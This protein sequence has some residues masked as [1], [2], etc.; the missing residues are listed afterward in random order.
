MIFITTHRPYFEEELIH[1]GKLQANLLLVDCAVFQFSS[2]I[3]IL[4]LLN[5]LSTSHVIT[6]FVLP[7]S[8]LL[9]GR[10][11]SDSAAFL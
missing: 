10:L 8:F 3:C 11:V 1:S 2:E 4:I 6:S 5:V 9:R 7:L